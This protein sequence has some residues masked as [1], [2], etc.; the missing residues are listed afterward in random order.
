MLLT[1]LLELD[2][3]T[4]PNHQFFYH[5]ELCASCSFIVVKSVEFGCLQWEKEGLSSFLLRTS[6]FDSLQKEFLI[7]A[8]NYLSGV[9]GDL[10]FS[11]GE[12]FCKT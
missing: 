12:F 3:T 10:Q 2:V 5:L 1:I 7:G 9:E 11:K 6:I 8:Y 4:F